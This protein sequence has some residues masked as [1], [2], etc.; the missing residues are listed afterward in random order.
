M[1]LVSDRERA[2]E[3]LSR[4]AAARAWARR[5]PASLVVRDV[6]VTGPAQVILRSI[7]EARG[8]RYQLQPAAKRTLEDVPGPDPWSAPIAQPAGAPVGHEL[9][10]PMPGTTVPM[11]CGMCGATG[12][13]HCQTCQGTGRVQHGNQSYRCT[14][15]GGR[16]VVVCVTCHGTGGL[17]GH[18][19][20]W[21]RIE[22]HEEVRA[23]GTDELPLDVAFDLTDTREAGELVHQQEAPRLH[24]LRVEG[25][26]RDAARSGDAVARMARALCDAPGV[27]V[28]GRIV[29]Q[30]L[31]VRRVPVF[32]VTLEGARTIWV[33]GEPPKV[34]PARAMDSAMLVAVR[35]VPWV[36]GAGA[37]AV[38]G[39]WLFG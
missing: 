11:D 9:T 32:V 14:H 36:L 5:A 17:V 28:G 38:G 4:Y 31:E 20:V 29:R 26:Y 30:R 22:A 19:T 2:L 25:G 23:L 33:W 37:V 34:S 35:V 15:C 27:P 18:P 39:W 8:V 21:S 12:E 13:A 24:E 1:S 16:G 10:Y 6:Q 3:L 7:F